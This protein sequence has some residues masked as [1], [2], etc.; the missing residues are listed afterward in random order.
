MP[1]ASA[2]PSKR[3]AKVW[4]RLGESEVI[5]ALFLMRTALLVVARWKTFSRN[6]RDLT[7]RAFLLCTWG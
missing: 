4:T 1:H 3:E 5:P 2:R 7:R 6:L